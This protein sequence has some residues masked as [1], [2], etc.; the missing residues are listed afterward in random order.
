MF[1]MALF[2]LTIITFAYDFFGYHS[3]NT[4]DHTLIFLVCMVN[5]D[6][7]MNLV[8]LKS[9][10]QPSLIL[11]LG[12]IV[13]VLGINNRPYFGNIGVV[14]LSPIGKSLGFTPYLV[15]GGLKSNLAAMY[16]K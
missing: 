9:K 14:C 12:E 10:V 6:V 5:E 2:I 3:M 4:L 15:V 8:S 16:T 13:S 1:I 11:R 7:F